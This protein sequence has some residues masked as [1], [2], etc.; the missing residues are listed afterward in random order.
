M[1]SGDQKEV[2]LL[3]VGAASL[4]SCIQT[5]ARTIAE[6]CRKFGERI[7]GDILPILERGSKSPN[8]RIREGVCL[9]MSELMS[10]LYGHLFISLIVPQ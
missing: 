7:L 8:D 2:S 5:A 10:V 9:A 4:R 3:F 6:L 1:P